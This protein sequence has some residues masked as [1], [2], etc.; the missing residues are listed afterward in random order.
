MQ[1]TLPDGTQADPQVL[2]MLK[3]IKQMEG[4]DYNNRTGDAGSSAGAFQWN[5]DNIPLKAGE[6]PSHW[7]AG[8]AKY[9]GDAKAPMTVANQ[10]E[11]AY[12]Q[13]K[14]YKDAGYGPD[15]IDALWNGASKDPAGKMIHNNS[16]R[17]DRFQAALQNAIQEKQQGFNP[18]PYSNPD[19]QPQ[20]PVAQNPA[21]GQTNQQDT[22]PAD[23]PFTATQPKVLT[24]GANSDLIK[25]A[26]NFLFPIVGDLKNDFTGQNNKTALQQ[27]GDAGLSVLPFIPGLGEAGEL[28][29]GAGLAARVAANPIARGA[30]VGYGAGV[31]Q[32]MSQGESIG[33]SFA[34]NINNAAGTILGA[35]APLAMKSIGAIRELASGMNPQ[36]ENAL[37]DTGITPELYNKYM[38]TAQERNQN[39]RAPAPHELSADYLDEASAKIK[40]AWNAA[41]KAVGE[42]KTAAANIQLPDMTPVIKGFQSEVESRYGIKLSI[43]HAGQI[44]TEMLPHTTHGLTSSEISRLGQT[45]RELNSLYGSTARNASDVIRS[46]SNSIDVAKGQSNLVKDPLEAFLGHTSDV[47]DKAMRPVAPT[48]ASANDTYSHLSEIRG[49]IAKMA[50]GNN[51]RGELLMRR[52]FSGDKSGDVQKLFDK[53]KAITGIDLVNHAVLAK[54]AI[55]SVGDSS[56]RTL[57]HQ[58]IGSAAGDGVPTLTSMALNAIR[59]GARK[60]GANPIKMGANIVNGKNPFMQ[61]APSVTTKSAIEAGARGLGSFAPAQSQ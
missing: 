61:W 46:I 48:L 28:A 1:P 45:F 51:Q 9:L 24:E 5:N 37:K 16:G 2:L 60:F 39:I 47:I 29:R 38:Q 41:G 42:A 14:A 58:V 33:Q 32:N 20:S 55:E 21:P 4:G 34:P 17:G 26:G 31:A 22:P 44:Q 19:T 25:Q 56:Q 36:I 11:V 6:N 35:G 3:V 13:I 27:V 52:V 23:N 40:D 49:E 18:K 50:G 12:K 7:M 15:E 57:L 54:H 59:A 8:A 43:D 30:A 53:I 10:N